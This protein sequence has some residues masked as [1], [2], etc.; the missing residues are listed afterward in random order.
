MSE[1]RFQFSGFTLDTKRR[2]LTRDG[3]EIELQ[4]RVFNLLLYLL[5]HR[6]RAVDKD[7]LME[8][9]WPG[10]VVTETAL[11]RAIMKARK[12]VEDDAGTQ[13]VIKTLHGHGYRFVAE[14]SVESKPGNAPATVEAT[15]LTNPAKPGR[16]S[17]ALYLSGAILAMTL[18]ILLLVWP[19]KDS[20]FDT[21][22]P[23]VA[24]LPVIDQTGQAEL[25]WARLGLMSF[26]SSLL[27]EDNA[28]QTVSDG[29]M[30]TLAESISWNGSIDETSAAELLGRLQSLYGATHLLTMELLPDRTQLRMNY[31]LWGSTG[32][33]RRGTMVGGEGPELAM[34]VVQSVYGQLLKRSRLAKDVDLVSE[35]PFNNEAFARGMSLSLEGRCADAVQYFRVILE[36]EPELF[37][38]SHELAA[39]LRVLGEPDEAEAILLPLIQEQR[40]L[41]SDQQLALAAKTL[42]ILYNRSGRLEEAE[43]IHTEALESAERTG[44]HELMASILTNLGIVAKDRG[45]ADA[46]YDLLDR[47]KLEYRQ[48]GREILPGYVHSLQANLAMGQGRLAEADGHLELALVA[49]RATGDLRRQAMM[50]NNTGYLRRLQGRLEEAETYHLQSMAI[51]EEI[52]DKVGVARVQN[53]LAVVYAGQGKYRQA[54]DVALAGIE[55][56]HEAKDRLFEATL[57]AQLADAERGLDLPDKAREAFLASRDI[58]EEIGDFSRALQVDLKLVALDMDIGELARAEETIHS[59]LETAR[60]REFLKP[61]LDALEM[62]G[63]IARMED[64]PA[65]A[66]KAY[67]D[68]LDRIRETSWQ[69]KELRVTRKLADLAME[70]GDLDSAEP[71][72]GRLAGAEP[73]FRSLLSQ[74]RFAHLAGDNDR[75]ASLATEARSIAGDDW[76]PEHESLLKEYTGGP[77][78]P[79]T[80]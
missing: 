18:I 3:R 29:S 49:F 36:Q 24:V 19:D 28:I 43:A 72:I 42:G 11:T 23:R 78:R 53:M 69:A 44:D 40:D 33:P 38:P 73:G 51:R 56:A 74:A 67:A 27:S 65:A 58:F 68:A 1:E 52:G 54:K 47:A 55:I 25:S 32:R 61:E 7:E 70:R 45:D 26:V 71:L 60:V 64:D 37:A 77:D 62:L 13:A 9:V 80:P 66:E 76:S 34:G 59:V 20:V 35:D 4:P 75:A 41:G 21:S 39:C 57:Y 17:L 14:L 79:K 15:T 50:L 46:A 8:A 22:Q 16:R 10:M 31:I 5:Q 48:S 6:D 12:A 63:D 30:L 2:E